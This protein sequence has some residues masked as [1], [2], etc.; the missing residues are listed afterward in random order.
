LFDILIVQLV[1]KMFEILFILFLL[2]LSFFIL[3]QGWKGGN[4]TVAPNGDFFF[5]FFSFFSFFFFFQERKME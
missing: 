2:L 4:P 1:L 3:G 5:L